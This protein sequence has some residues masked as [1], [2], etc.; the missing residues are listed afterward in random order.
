MV[1]PPASRG[2]RKGQPRAL[3][4][5]DLVVLS[6]LLE[7]PMHGYDLLA[8]YQRQEVADWAS[9]SKAQLYYALKKLAQLDLLS[10]E[11]DDTGGRDR[12]VFRVTAEGVEALKTGLADNGWAVGRVAQPFTTWVGLSI[13]ADPASRR[14]V[15]RQR[16]EFLTAEI[17]KETQ[18][19]AYIETMDDPRAKIGSDIVKLTLKQLATEQEWIT[20]ILQRDP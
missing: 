18:S 11:P 17:A 20:E 12:M 1:G 9:I 14:M 5:A 15:F 7:T 16:L 3:T 13:H 2:R 8:E 10:G 4:T 19:L 6:L